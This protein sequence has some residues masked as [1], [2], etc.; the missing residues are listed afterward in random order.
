M[1]WAG[2]DDLG[3]AADADAHELAAGALLRLLH[4]QVVVAD[5]VERLLERGRVIARVVRPAGRRLVR[6]LLRLDEVLHPQLGRVLADLVGEDVDHALDGMDRLGHP[7]RAAVGHAAGRLVRVD[8]ID[9]DEGVG[10]VVRAGDDV[11]QAGRVLGRVGRG[12]GVAMVRDG[13]GLERGDLAVLGR[14]HLGVDVVVAGERVGLQVLAAILD[15]LDRLADEER[16]RDGQDVARVDRHLAAE[17]AADVVG[18]H[19]DVLFADRKAGAGGDERDHG[20]DGVRR[21]GRHV[22]RELLAD[23]V[24]VGDAA[25]RL[26]RGDV[27]ARDVDVLLDVDVGRGEV[28]VRGRPIAGL[29][30][31]DVV[32]LLVLAAIRAQDRRVGLERLERIGHDRQ[33]LVVHEHRGHAVGGDVLGRR[34]DRRD[35]L[36]LVHDGVDREHHLHVAGQRRHPVELVALEILAG[37]DR[38]RRPGS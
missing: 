32:V 28:R 19:P 4:P 27:D 22:Q 8:A 3:E 6:E 14:A 30:V 13:L 37:D 9:F 35:L 21:L 12:V 23:R 5:H 34:D 15:P 2:P 1:R 24:P 33:R 29:P 38:E 7:E 10:E 20:A 36:G 16:R 17:A 18:L 11:E 31:P 25:A 26:D